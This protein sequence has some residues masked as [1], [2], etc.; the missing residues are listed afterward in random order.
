M[1][2]ANELTLWVTGVK[3][4]EGEQWHRVILGRVFLRRYRLAYDGLTG[5][6]EIIEPDGSA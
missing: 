4:Y 2:F 6:V 1:M 3:L 5:Q